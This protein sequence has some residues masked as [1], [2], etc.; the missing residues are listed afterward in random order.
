MAIFELEIADEDVQRVLN[1]ICQN[2]GWKEQVPNP[3][4]TGDNEEPETV[5]NPE[6]KGNF[7][8]RMVRGFLSEHVRAYEIN[9]A[10][11]EAAAN[12]DAGVVIN[13][14]QP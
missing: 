10:R 7:T 12:V 8:H 1:A 2:Y 11:D 13:N 9:K 4:Y 3:S 5:E 6:T 14:P